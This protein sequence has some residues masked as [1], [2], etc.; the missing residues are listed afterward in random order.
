MS[1]DRARDLVRDFSTA[2]DHHGLVPPVCT[3]E[4]TGLDLQAIHGWLTEVG[5]H[6]A[7]RRLRAAEGVAVHCPVWCQSGHYGVQLVLPGESGGEHQ[8]QRAA[9]GQVTGEVV[10]WE[11]VDER[12]NVLP[13][14][15][16]VLTIAGQPEPCTLTPEQFEQLRE[17]VNALRL[18][19]E[20]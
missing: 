12:G 8:Y 1:T 18:P 4:Q 9:A 13:T 19:G 7:Y 16:V 14:R 17:V 3:D 2:V 11:T 15:E 10:Q 5:M 20:Q 6:G